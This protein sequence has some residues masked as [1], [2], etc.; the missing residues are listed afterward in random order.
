MSESEKGRGDLWASKSGL[1]LHATEWCCQGPHHERM[2]VKDH[3]DPSYFD[4]PRFSLCSFALLS[5]ERAKERA[6]E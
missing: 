6:D 5:G 1:L 2:Q 3:A 4:S